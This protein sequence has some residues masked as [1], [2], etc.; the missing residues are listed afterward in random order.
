MLPRGFAARNYLNMNNKK[1][2]LGF[3]TLDQEVVIEELPIRGA[4]PTWL[5]GTLVRNGPAKFEV[6]KK[7]LR[8]WFDGL[9]MLHKF[10]FHQ[11]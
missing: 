6:G 11:G 3:S 2:S 10:C 7:K 9:A 4:L 5:S 8:H 1:F